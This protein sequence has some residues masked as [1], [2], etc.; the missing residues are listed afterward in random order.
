MVV[1]FENRWRR[2]FGSLKEQIPIS[3]QQVEYSDPK[4]GFKLE[5]RRMVINNNIRTGIVAGLSH[6]RYSR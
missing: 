2:N 5:A 1:Q 4:Q 3:A 6:N